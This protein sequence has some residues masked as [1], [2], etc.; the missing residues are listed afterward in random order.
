[1]Y[2]HET[3][4]RKNFESFLVLLL[5]ADCRWAIFQFEF[6]KKK[7]PSDILSTAEKNYQ[8]GMNFSN[9]NFTFCRDVQKVCAI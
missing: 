2:V 8:K 6:K 9:L 5:Y 1:M 4:N 7:I 3:Y